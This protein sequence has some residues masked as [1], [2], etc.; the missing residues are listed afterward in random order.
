MTE[1]KRRIKEKV[2][3]L[4]DLSLPQ[5]ARDLVIETDAS[6]KA[7]GG[8]LIEKHRDREKTHGFALG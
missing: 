8:V 7:R 3:Q 5:G 6:S 4:L 2:K 1:P